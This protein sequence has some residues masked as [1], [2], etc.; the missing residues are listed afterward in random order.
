[1]NVH[2]MAGVYAAAVTPV[3]YDYSPDYEALPT[4]LDFLAR[5]GCHGALILGTTGEG[6]SFTA[7]EREQIWQSALEV[8]DEHREFR[9]FAGT[10]TPSLDETIG[11]TKT[12]FDLGYDGVVVLPPYYFHKASEE[13]LF[14]WF[15][16]VIARGV[17]RN[18]LVMGYHFPQV[19][20][21]RL[22][23][24]LLMRLKDTFPGE[25]KGIKDSSGKLKYAQGLVSTMGEDFLT[26]VGNDRIFSK[27]LELGVDGCITALANLQS[28]DLRIIWDSHLAGN[29]DEQAQGHVNVGR[30]IIERYPQVAPAIKTLL[31][32]LHDIPM[33]EVRPPLMPLDEEDVQRALREMMRASIR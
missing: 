3:K 32:G 33:W 4:L 7:E 1:M 20:G 14:T 29:I 12:A 15:C 18:G 10:G 2:P 31:N 17:P 5:R 28:P 27:A 21:V 19:S 23:L 13:G 22:S 11:L 16:E 25:F 30:E 24:E 26:L 9:L 6:P 8:R